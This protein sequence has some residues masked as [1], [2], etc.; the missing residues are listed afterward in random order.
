MLGRSPRDLGNRLPDR[1][2]RMYRKCGLGL[3]RSAHHGD[4]GSRSS[5]LSPNP[6]GRGAMPTVGAPPNLRLV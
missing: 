5:I 4:E 6:A 3:N 2:I 1:P